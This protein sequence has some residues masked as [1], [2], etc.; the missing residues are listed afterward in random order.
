MLLSYCLSSP[1][2]FSQTATRAPFAKRR[3]QVKRFCQGA[4]G[5]GWVVLRYLMLKLTEFE[6]PMPRGEVGARALR[7][8]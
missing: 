1:P 3:P 6:K 4:L 2:L 7:V 5:V 8:S